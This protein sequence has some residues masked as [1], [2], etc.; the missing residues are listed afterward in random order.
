MYTGQLTN[1]K[2]GATGSTE[3]GFSLIELMIVVVIIG[4]IAAF[5][6]PSYTK[7]VTNTNRGAAKSCLMEVANY[8][9]R[10]KTTNLRYDQ[11]ANGNKIDS[12]GDLPD[13]DCVNQTSRNYSYTF[14]NGKPTQTKYTIVATPIGTQLAQDTKCGTLSINQSGVKTANNVGAC[15]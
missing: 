9:E 7:Y 4:I 12:F 8:M 6:Y 15:W 11:D 5:A 13:F 2:G 10:F 1:K 14:K 3:A